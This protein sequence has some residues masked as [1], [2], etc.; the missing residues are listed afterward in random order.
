[1]RRRNSARVLGPYLERGKW[2]LIIVEDVGRRSV[3]FPTR[4]EALKFK[5]SAKREI[6]IPPS[7]RIADV[8]EQWRTHAQRS[9]KCKPK[10][11][12][13]QYRRLNFFLSPVA[14][15]DIAALTP[16]RAAALYEEAT[17]RP[18]PRTGS[19]LA[20]ASQRYDLWAAQCFFRWA[21]RQGYVGSTP[22]RDVKPTG[23]VNAGKPQLRIEEARRFTAAALDYFEETQ[24]PLAIG[25]LLA[26]TLGLRTS[27]VI[28]RVVRDLDDGARYLWIDS[29]KTASARRH[30]EVPELVR[31][32]LLRLA[33]GKRSDALLFG[34]KRKG[35][36]I[37][38]QT[39]WEMVQRLCV[40]AGVPAVCTHSLRGLW[41]T[42][43]VQSGAASHVV[44]AN[45]GHHSFEMTERHYAQG[46]A[47]KNAA[48]ARVLGMLGTPGSSARVS[49]KAQLEQLDEGTLAQLLALLAE[50]RN[51]GAPAN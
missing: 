10:T 13:H 5:A 11:I 24:H 15:F 9:A 7:R 31:S 45:L 44:A 27:E 26:L 16:N 30:L 3:F 48:T 40:R 37:R 18:S 23:K 36:P 12:D 35:G 4:E 20:A 14:D 1:M 6:A 50:S 33:S 49:A 8:I 22:F 47:V 21:I 39:M 51:D 46:S 32:H 43:A 29:G 34:E 2:R 41:A 42:L 28:E 25:A 19:V 38:R 17:Q